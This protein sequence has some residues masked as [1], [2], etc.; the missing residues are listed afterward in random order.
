MLRKYVPKAAR[1]QFAVLMR[2]LLSDI[3]EDPGNSSLWFREELRKHPIRPQNRRSIPQMII[4]P[5]RVT[6]SEVEQAV[7]SFPAGSTGSL[8]GLRPQQLKDSLT[9]PS[10]D[11][12]QQLLLTL[13]ELV[14][15]DLSGNVSSDI[16]PFFAG[17]NLS[18]FC[19]KSGGIRPIAVEETLRR[20]SA[21][22]V[23]KRLSF[24]FRGFLAPLILGF[25]VPAGAESALQ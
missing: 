22:C 13:T 15:L 24:L 6:A 16:T 2:S 7:R 21:K 18:A 19:K 9:K 10:G 17:A 5:V 11:A 3:I 12:A 20:L 14:N 1:Y 8:S 25:A 23:A 4:E